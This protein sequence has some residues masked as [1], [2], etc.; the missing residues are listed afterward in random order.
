MEKLTQIYRYFSSRRV[1]GHAASASFFMVLAFFPTLVLLLSLVRYAGYSVETLTEVLAGVVPAA[2]RPEA[3]KLIHNTYYA[4][5]GTVLS[6]SALTALWSAGRGV[7]GVLVGLNSVYD[8]QENRG[9]IRTRVISV[10][11]TFSFLVVLL[12][13]LILH[14]FGKGVFR[15]ISNLDVPLLSL[16]GWVVQQRFVLLL[17]LQTFLFTG[18]Y[19]FLPGKKNKFGESFFGALLA[20]VGW[21]VVSLLFSVY[22]E[23]FNSYS[24]I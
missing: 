14:V 6:L 9:Y 1:T 10:A 5:S 19:M 22:V 4:T 13:T 16:I 15:W 18:M 21:Q 20:A 11:Y 8:V 3:E 12:L 2:L 17:I 24:N 23:N 7:H